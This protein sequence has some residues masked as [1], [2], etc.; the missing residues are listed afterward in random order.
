MTPKKAKEKL[1]WAPTT[2]LE[3]MVSEMITEDKEEAKKEAYLKESGFTV[4]GTME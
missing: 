3:E 1:N 4:H 2:T